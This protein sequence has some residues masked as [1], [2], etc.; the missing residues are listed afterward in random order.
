MDVEKNPE[1][2]EISAQ[3]TISEKGPFSTHPFDGNLT[4]SDENIH[5]QSIIPDLNQKS[6]EKVVVVTSMSE[7]PLS[8]SYCEEPPVQ[9][10]SHIGMLKCFFIHLFYD[11]FS[12]N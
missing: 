3:S 9:S 11:C 2:I 10:T 12:I 4:R 5:Q 7:P 8:G 6:I 1:N